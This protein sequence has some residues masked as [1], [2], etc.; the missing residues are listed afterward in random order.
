[1]RRRRW[2]L[3]IVLAGLILVVITHFTNMEDLGTAFGRG[4]WQWLIAAAAAQL[5]YFLLYAALYHYGFHTVDVQSRSREL[6]PI[7][8][9]SIV[10][11]QVAPLGGA[12][13]A[14]LFVDDAVR[15]GQE[16]GRAAAGVMFVLV[17]DLLSIFPFLAYGLYTLSRRGVLAGYDLLLTGMFA[18][19]ALGLIGVLLLARVEEDLLHRVLTWVRR[20]VSWVGRN[21]RRPNLLSEDWAEKGT[22]QYV[23]ASR[24]ILHHGRRVV[25]TL[26]MGFAV[27][28]ASAASLYALILAFYQP[29][30]FGTL[31]AT[32]AMGYVTFIVSIIPE[33]IAAIEAVMAATFTR[34]D[35]PGG[36]A[37]AIILV[38]RGLAFWIPL[39]AGAFVFRRMRLFSGQNDQ[40]QAA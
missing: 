1:M 8:F 17:A 15:R 38:N 23:A 34:L 31:A 3:W 21:V 25:F 5:I 26:I 28:L 7:L 24:A 6:I 10:A 32:F 30:S 13:G 16:G 33:D 27:S 37:I 35:V 14:A 29:V 12:A 39:I 19:F 20:I 2:I 11:N 22:R 18:A 4:K 36:A 40:R 9:A